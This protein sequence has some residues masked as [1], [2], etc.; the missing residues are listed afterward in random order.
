MPITAL[1]GSSGG[2]KASP[3]VYKKAKS[4]GISGA[5]GI[6]NPQPAP[7]AVP[8]TPGAPASSAIQLSPEV[9]KW[10][11]EFGTELS[12]E[13]ANQGPDPLLME[14]VQNL[15]NRLSTDTTGRAI[16][17]AGSKIADAAAGAKAGMRTNLARRG[18]SGTGAGEQQLEQVDQ[19]AQRA[20][21]G[22]AA[23]ISLGREHDL[24]ALVLG[25]EG[26]MR[27]PGEMGLAKEGQILSTIGQGAGNA[28][29][30]EQLAQGWAGVGNQQRQTDIAAQ[31][32]AMVQYLALMRFYGAAA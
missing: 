5:G 28:A 24:D 3:D 9:G 4:Q 16:D 26:I 27:A 8:G 6:F 15:R 29:Q 32:Q 17:R 10:G 11:S 13:R 7:A 21:A 19:A 31:N 1:G 12:K 2:I 23:D 18:I 30:R 22:S 20:Q 25:G 14:N